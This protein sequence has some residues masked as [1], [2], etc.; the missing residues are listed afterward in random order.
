MG[1]RAIARGDRN[2]VAQEDTMSWALQWGR[3]RS[4]AEMMA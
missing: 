4:P 1:P 2:Y 3:G